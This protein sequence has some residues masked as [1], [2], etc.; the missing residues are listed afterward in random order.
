MRLIE[1]DKYVVSMCKLNEGGP[2]DIIIL[3]VESGHT[4]LVVEVPDGVGAW[5]G[6]RATYRG[7]R[8]WCRG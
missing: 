1:N 8:G 2:R 7:C 4:P 6:A 3:Y 5:S